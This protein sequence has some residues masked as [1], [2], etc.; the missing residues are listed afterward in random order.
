VT[1]SNGQEPASGKVKKKENLLFNLVF[2]V[3]LPA[4]ILIKLSPESRLGPALALVVGC[5]LPLGYGIYDY[6]ARHEVNPFSVL[7]LVAVLIKGTFGLFKLDPFFFACSEAALPL[8]FGAAFAYTARWEPPLVERFLFSPQML[9]VDKVRRKLALRGNAD[10]LRPL[11]VQT[12]LAYA[13][14]MLISASMNFGLARLILKTKP[15]ENY[16]KY[17]DE[18]GRFTGLQYPVIAI[19]LTVITVG[20]LLLVFKRLS[21]LTGEP[22]HYFLPGGEE[23]ADASVDTKS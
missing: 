9:D 23:P 10:K 8:L 16:Q 19:P 15:H 5:S 12:T 18:I 3:A 4:F 22:A 11:M 13:A 20:L 7:G 21:S 6:F 2:N 1:A 17:V 14:T